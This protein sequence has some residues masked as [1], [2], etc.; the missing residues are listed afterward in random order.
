[1]TRNA[2]PPLMAHPGWTL[3][4]PFKEAKYFRTPSESIGNN[5][6]PNANR[7]RLQEMQRPAKR[8]RKSPGS[9]TPSSIPSKSLS[10]IL[11]KTPCMICHIKPLIF[12]SKYF[13]AKVLNFAANIQNLKR[14]IIILE[15]A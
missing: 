5:F 10:T 14:I 7:L 9:E 13:F 6:S 11:S 2:H 1:M 8:S 4:I 12:N 15:I 3:A